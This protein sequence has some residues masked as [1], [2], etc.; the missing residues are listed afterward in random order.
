M[1]RDTDELPAIITDLEKS[2]AS[3]DS[4]QYSHLTSLCKSS[5]ND[6]I[7]SDELLAAQHAAQEQLDSHR[8]TLDD[9]D[10]LGDILTEMLERQQAVEV[11]LPTLSHVPAVTQ[12]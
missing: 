8:T 9:L 12:C 5:A 3:I 6:A 1:D 7:C 4:S 10:E 11:R 2:M